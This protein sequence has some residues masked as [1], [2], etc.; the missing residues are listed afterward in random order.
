[1]SPT[2]GVERSIPGTSHCSS[3]PRPSPSLPALAEQEPEL[4]PEDWHASMRV[5]AHVLRAFEHPTATRD[6]P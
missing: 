3:A 1:M 2:A 4:A 5:V 6:D